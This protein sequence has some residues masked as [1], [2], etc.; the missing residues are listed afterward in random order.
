MLDKGPTHGDIGCLGGDEGRGMQSKK[1]VRFSSS[2]KS[3]VEQM[4]VLRSF[5]VKKKETNFYY[6]STICFT[7][8]SIH[9]RYGRLIINIMVWCGFFFQMKNK[10][11]K[12]QS[13]VDVAVLFPVIKNFFFVCKQI[14]KQFNKQQT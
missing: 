14:A 2:V 12:Y 6:N 7:F 11:K 4:V 3:T 5:N 8:Y 1:I 13:S 9:C 10:T